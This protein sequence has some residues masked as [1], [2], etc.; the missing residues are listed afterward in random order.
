MGSKYTNC[1]TPITIKGVEFKNR[2]VCTPNVCGWGSREGILTQEQTAYY[3]RIASGGAAIVTIGNCSINMGETSDEIHQLD[4]SADKVVFGLNSLREKVSRYNGHLSA[5]INYCGRNGWYPGS[6]HYA[7][8]ALP[9]PGQIERAALEGGHPQEVIE[10][11]PK[12]IYEI[13]DLYAEAA[14]RLKR[15]GFKIIQVHCAHN[16]L[17]GQF[18]SPISNFRTDQY[19]IRSIED[20]TRFG[21]EVLEAMRD[22][23]GDGMIID[24]RMSGEDVMPGGLGRDEAVAIAKLLEPYIDIFTISNAFHAP[25]SYIAD[26]LS[27]SYLLPQIPLEEYTKPFRKALK[28]S[29]LVFTTNVVNLDNAEYILKEGI[30]D[31]VGMFRPFL[32]DPEIVKKYSRNQ[33]E[34]VNQ[35][36]RCE[37]HNRFALQLPITCAVNPFCGKELEYPEGRVPK[38][39]EPRKVLVAGGGPAGL[40]AAWTAA[41]RG[42]EV[43]LVEKSRKLGGNLLKSGVLPFKK[44]FNKFIDYLIPRVEKSG[45]KIV[46]GTVVD[47]NFVAKEN[48]DIL[49]LAVGSED[50]VPLIPGINNP[51]VHFCWQADEKSVSVGDDVIIIG[52]GLVGM[53][54]ALYLGQNGKNVTIIE[55]QAEEPSIAKKG[56]LGA[57]LIAQNL[58]AENDIHYESEVLE[59]KDGS[60]I[61]VDNRT[62]ERTELKADTVLLAAGTHPCRGTVEELRHLIAEGDVYLIG[63]L[64]DDGGTIGHAINSGFEVAAHI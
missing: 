20:R 60:V 30:A 11:T 21:R 57:P 16:N 29:K 13:I 5:Q 23:V 63:D 3:E 10:L 61:S 7:P 19:G 15:A 64:T 50:N 33:V 59:I 36:I 18:F 22:K 26:K 55:R 58:E 2:I 49:I 51:H 1:F 14:L 41:Q 53:E 47:A 45:A 46:L 9:S 6:I 28:N 37:Y 43:T 32:A 24:A 27:L 4:L 39:G 31:F 25:P 42:H 34:E 44:E 40:Q 62:G 52:A 35:C 56:A 8:T 38:T 12:K 54:T 48:P 17:I